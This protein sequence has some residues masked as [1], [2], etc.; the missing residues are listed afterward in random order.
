MAQGPIAIMPLSR[1]VTLAAVCP[2][3]SLQ[4]EP[5]YL[6]KGSDPRGHRAGHTGA[7]LS[8]GPSCVRCTHSSCLVSLLL[9][10][11]DVGLMAGLF[12]P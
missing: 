2:L 10:G 12:C 5:S 1:M 9:L 8:L 7:A 11:D 6:I 3:S 4:M